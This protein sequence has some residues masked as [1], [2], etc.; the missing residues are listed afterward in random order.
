MEKQ[1]E[2]LV[3]LRLAA[4]LVRR[5]G[6]ID[7]PVGFFLGLRIA[8]AYPEWARFMV[9]QADENTDLGLAELDADMRRLVAAFPVEV[10]Q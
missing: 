1:A 8:C 3:Y 6:S 4:D 5:S 9:E 2:G 7:T 10:L